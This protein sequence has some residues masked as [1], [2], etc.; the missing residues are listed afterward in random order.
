MEWLAVYALTA[1]FTA[2][3][4]LLVTCLLSMDGQSKVAARVGLAAPFL[5]LLWP[6]TWAYL[7]F[8]GVRALIRAADLP[9][10]FKKEN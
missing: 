7:L 4:C 1:L 8:N 5:S 6:L 2:S 3:C 10:L 9:E